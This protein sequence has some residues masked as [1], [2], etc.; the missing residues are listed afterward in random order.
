MKIFDSE[1]QII[2]KKITQGNGFSRNLINIIDSYQNLSGT[3]IKIDIQKKAAY[4][5]FE[6]QNKEPTDFEVHAGI[7][8]QHQRIY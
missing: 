6:I 1:E 7:K 8:K 3:R 4:F 2:I 5:L